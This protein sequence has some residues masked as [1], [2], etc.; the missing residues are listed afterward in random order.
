M[1][2]LE[3]SPAPAFL[4]TRTRALIYTQEEQESAETQW[5]KL[6]CHLVETEKASNENLGQNDA[7]Q[8]VFSESS[9]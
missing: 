5:K 8:P 2:L 9:F 7:T 1:L 6:T 3:A 4:Q